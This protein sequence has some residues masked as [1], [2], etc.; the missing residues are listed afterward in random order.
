MVS[1][2]SGDMVTIFFQTGIILYFNSAT[3]IFYSEE[4]KYIGELNFLFGIFGFDNIIVSDNIYA[5]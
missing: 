3:I 2:H 4:S 5:I 1:N